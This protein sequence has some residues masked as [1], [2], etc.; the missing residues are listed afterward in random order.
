MRG[1]GPVVHL[2]RRQK[3]RMI[4]A[5][6]ADALG[7][8]VRGYR[9]LDIGCGNG[10]IS[11]HFARENEHYGVDIADRRREDAKGFVF[12]LVESERLP[13]ADGFFDIVISHHV[14]EHVPD[15]ALHLSEIRRVLKPRG[16]AYLATPNKSSPIMEGHV[17]NDLVL[18]YHAMAPFFERAG[19]RVREY[20]TEVLR[21]PGRFH[22]EV[23][24]GRFLPRFLLQRLRR[25]FPSHV[26]VLR[27]DAP[28]QTA[29]SPAEQEMLLAETR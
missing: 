18:R 24:W 10:G 9:S 14:I 2:D 21:Q 28:P 27:P 4:E 8:P 22:G 20:A 7:R 6:L 29:P 3:A 19:F 23:R 11:S 16:V 15:Q 1:R 13:F 26:F 17:G 12:R 25:F 5:V